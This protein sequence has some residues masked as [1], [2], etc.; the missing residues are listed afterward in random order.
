MSANTDGITVLMHKKSF[1]TFK[2]IVFKFED[3]LN[4]KTKMTF[5]KSLHSQNVNSYIAVKEDNTIKIKGFLNTKNTNPQA[6]IVKQS[7]CNYVVNNIKIDD[8]FN[9]KTNTKDW[10][11]GLSTTNG[12][13]VKDA[14]AGINPR[15]IWSNGGDDI[16]DDRGHKLPFGKDIT[17]VKD[18]SQRVV[19]CKA[20]YLDLALKAI[21]SFGLT[22]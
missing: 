4:L 14:Y 21:D 13:F 16:K 10:V 19:P 11:F 9:I 12:S 22:Y 5:Y 15:W 20:R 2:D 17:L 1:D 8:T 3:L 18:L 7:V 6:N